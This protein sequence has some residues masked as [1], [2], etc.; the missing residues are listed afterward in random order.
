M[1]FRAH[2]INIFASCHRAD[3][4][5]EMKAK[6]NYDYKKY[7]YCVPPLF[8]SAPLCFSCIHHI[9]HIFHIF[10]FQQFLGLPHTQIQYSQF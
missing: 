10:K 8:L 3:C 2:S 6:K 7:L 9:Y 1:S 5:D 4:V